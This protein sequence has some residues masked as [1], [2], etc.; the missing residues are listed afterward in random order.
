MK[1][2]GKVLYSS[3]LRR[4]ATGSALIISSSQCVT[5]RTNTSRDQSCLFMNIEILSGSPR[6]GSL[7]HRV[8]LH[9]RQQLTERAPLHN[10]G[11]ISM[12]DTI[13]PFIQSVWQT[14]EHIPADKQESAYRVFD[15][16]AFI[17]VSPEYNGGYSPALKNFLDHFPKQSRKTFAV[18]TSS[19]GA[20]GGMRSAQALLHLVP[21]LQGIV[22]P[23]LLI[24]PAVEKKFDEGGQLLDESFAKNIGAFLNDFLWLAERVHEA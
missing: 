11:L 15:A 3:L 12:Q 5:C 7:S 21:A 20:L 18:A 13:Y 2:D 8:A 17:L 10:T 9:L 24:T 1:A 6:H 16:D 4:T 14:K 19:P 23:T 22:S